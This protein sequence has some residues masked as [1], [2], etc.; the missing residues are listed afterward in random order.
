[1]TETKRAQEPRPW[2]ELMALLDSRGMSQA[3]LGRKAGY[4]RQY[5]N[6]MARGRTPVGAR[7]RMLF[8]D[9]LG[10]RQSQLLPPEQRDTD[11]AR[12][13]DGTAHPTR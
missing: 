10:V 12:M 11:Y 13:L 9:I 2:V 5:V 7:A 8:A 1:M 3:E 6:E 4:T